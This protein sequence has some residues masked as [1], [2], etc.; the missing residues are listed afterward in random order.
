M[1]PKILPA[2]VLRLLALGVIALWSSV[3][4]AQVPLVA[5]GQPQA[6][7]LTKP[8]PLGH[9]LL[10]A[11]ELQGHVQRMTGVVLPIDLVGTEASYPGKRFVYIGASTATTAAGISTVGLD[12]EFYVIRTVGLHLYIVGRDGGQDE[13]FDLTDC[14]PGTMFGVYHLLNEVLGVRWI[15]PGE[16]GV[17]APTSSSLTVPLLD[18]TTGPAMVQRKYRTPRIGLYLNATATTYGFGVPVVPADSAR[19]NTLALEEILWLRRMRMGTRKSP[20]FAH[21]FTTWWTQYGASHPEYFAELLPGRTQPH[22]AADRV[23]LHDSSAA[24]WQRRVDDWQAAGAPS[25]LNI[26]PNDSRSFCVCANCLAL[27]RPSQ[28]P[29]IVFSSSE[30]LLGDRIAR[31]Y[32]EIANRVKLINPNATVYGYA[33]DVYK[34]PP[35]EMML[36]DN[37]ALAYIPGATSAALLDRMAET[38]SDVLGWIAK[39]CTQMYL[40][41]NWML[42][43]HAGPFWPT[44]RL[45]DHLKRMLAGG[46][47]RGFDSD[48]SC[49]SYASFGL[50]HYLVCRLLANPSLTVDNIL[51]EYCT[52][53]GSA[54]ARV[55]DYFSFWENFVYNQGD[56][57]NVDIVSW[58]TTVPAYGATYS[59]DAFDGALQI[60]DAAY[61]QLAPSES[62]ARDR[63]DFLRLACVHG[64]LTAKAISLVSPTLSLANNPAAEKAM[65][66]L[67]AFRDTHAESFALW[68]EWMIDREGSF[69]PNMEAYWTSILAGP[70]IGTGSNVNAF[71]ESGNRVVMEAEH[72][73]GKVAGAGLAAGWAWEENTTTAGA[74]G[75]VMQALPNPGTSTDTQLYGPRLDFKV[76]FRTTGTWYALIRMPQLP[77]S[78]NSIHVGLDGVVKSTR[79]ETGATDWRFVTTNNNGVRI[80]F[81]VATPGVHT[82]NVWMREDGVIIDRIILTTDAGFTLSPLNSQGPAESAR[83]GATEHLLTVTNGKGDGIF[84]EYSMVPITANAAPAGYVFDRWIGAIATVTNSFAAN[85][86]VTLG[87]GDLQLRATYKLDPA[88]DSDNDGISD[89]W[90]STHFNGLGPAG[91]GTD[92]DHDAMSDRDEF[93]A[94]TAPKD[95]ESVFAIKSITRSPITGRLTIEWPAIVGKKYR[96][97]N[98]PDLQAGVWTPLAINITGVAP[99]TSYTVDATTPAG[100]FRVQVE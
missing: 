51:D 47:L 42:S 67:L 11:Q 96:L 37:V 88:T 21:S 100:F 31:F 86:Y 79:V 29:D 39:G 56:G 17:V 9:V 48:S 73:T 6:V 70:G 75:T 63:L 13:W 26:C 69:V 53:F 16:S 3:L 28:A 94:G 24:V 23:K 84:G 41:P 91:L 54:A 15:W 27:D 44:R 68:R 8:A 10:A 1:P 80:S 76:D 46:Y 7:I 38:E 59:D 64:R 52:G 32:T 87:T 12:T 49:S 57:G 85:T 19:R 4:Q 55:R 65:R 81:D 18:L 78:D 2:N 40:R 43:G 74:V 93:L 99:F 22:P 62:A 45:G 14:Q 95:A 50:Y 82:L 83:R 34:R 90:E 89:A 35:L 30:A 33:Y 72:F 66:S 58:A 36:P 92:N 20:A 77:G 60:L 61:A 97:L 25:N 71:I 5:A 98:S